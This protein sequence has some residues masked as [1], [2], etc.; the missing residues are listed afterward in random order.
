LRQLIRDTRRSRSFHT[1]DPLPFRSP[2]SAYQAQAAELLAGWNTN[3]PD[4]VQA[5]RQHLS[6]LLEARIP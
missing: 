1:L 4:A 2:L 5:I 6:R 3:D